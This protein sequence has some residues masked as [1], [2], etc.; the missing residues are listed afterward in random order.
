MSGGVWFSFPQRKERNPSEQG[1]ELDVQVQPTTTPPPGQGGS[2]GDDAAASR[3]LQP[4]EDRCD[5]DG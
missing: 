3:C 1:K 5:L 4:I 2:F